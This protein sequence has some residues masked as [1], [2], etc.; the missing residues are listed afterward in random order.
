MTQW[1]KNHPQRFASLL[2]GVFTQIQGSLAL[3]QLPLPPLVIWAFNTLISVVMVCLAW[4]VKNTTDQ[5]TPQ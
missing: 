3:A 5:E 2:L 4:T 1:I